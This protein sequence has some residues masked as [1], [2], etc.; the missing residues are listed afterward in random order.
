M[1]HDGRAPLG[2]IGDKAT[3]ALRDIARGAIPSENMVMSLPRRFARVLQQRDVLAAVFKRIE[4]FGRRRRGR[5]TPR[6]LEQIIADSVAVLDGE[7][8]ADGV[9]VQLPES[10]TTVT[11]DETELQQVFVNLLRNSLHWLR[12]VPEQDRRLRIA[13]SRDDDGVHV[14]FSDSGPGVDDAV[15][16]RIFDPYFSTA[17]SGVGL[18]LSIAGEI[19]EE[20]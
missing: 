6:E 17:E 9:Q 8:H 7:I 13:I 3:L 12:E 16:D 10:H 5:P 1:L 2:K 20:Y 14:L 4:P 11:A 15:R 18:G 19:V